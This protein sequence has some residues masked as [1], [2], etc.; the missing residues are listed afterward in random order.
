MG[1]RQ[2]LLDE[3]QPV[4]Q[5][6]D[7]TENNITYDESLHSSMVTF[8]DIFKGIFTQYV[9]CT[10]CNNI[11]T[12]EIPFRELMLNFPEEHHTGDVDC[13]LKYLFHHHYGQNKINDYQCDVCTRLTLA[14][15]CTVISQFP[16][17]LCIHLGRKKPD[18]T[19]INSHVANHV[20]GNPVSCLK[21]SHEDVGSQYDLLGT[22]HHKAKKRGNSG[23][24][25]AVCKSQVSNVWYKYD[26]H[27]VHAETFVSKR[28]TRKPNPNVLKRFH[29]SA[30]MLFYVKKATVPVN[31][32]KLLTIDI[33]EDDHSS[34]SSSS[35]TSESH[36]NRYGSSDASREL[37]VTEKP[38]SITLETFMQRRANLSQAFLQQKQGHYCSVKNS[39]QHYL[40]STDL[41][42]FK[43]DDNCTHIYCYARLSCMM[44]HQPDNL[45]C[46]D[47]QCIA[48]NIILHQP[49]R[50][51]NGYA[52]NVN[53]PQHKLGSH[54]GHT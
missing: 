50:L 39:K 5:Q 37:N 31:P 29:R 20:L 23:H 3:L 11:S 32:N 22:V 47:C 38:P 1:L 44:N 36:I 42:T 34:S 6:S 48:T 10:Q 25:T 43:T 27:Q 26:D 46:P 7:D 15:Q 4:S 53:I 17:I 13:T 35:H 2:C 49:I 14:H 16:K 19:I 21:L 33:E 30:S 9:T 52:Y 41:A 54:E 18:G 8:W 51:N 40:L 24:Y 12:T 45:K 28:S